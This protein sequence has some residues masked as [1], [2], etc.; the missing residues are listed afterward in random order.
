MF[1]VLDTM[2]ALSYDWI[3]IVWNL[4]FIMQ[5][6]LH[7]SEFNFNLAKFKFVG[8]IEIVNNK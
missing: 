6:E 7:F 3:S 4:L 8:A 5:N 2:F 1:F